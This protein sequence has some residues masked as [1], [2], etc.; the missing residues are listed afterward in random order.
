M[1]Q[2]S[3][4]SME[5]IIHCILFVDMTTHDICLLFLLMAIVL[6]CIWDCY[7]YFISIVICRD[8][9]FCCAN[10]W[11]ILPPGSSL[12][13]SW[14]CYNVFCPSCTPLTSHIRGNILKHDFPHLIHHSLTAFPCPYVDSLHHIFSPLS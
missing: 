13:H 6:I 1:Y 9:L 14:D 10:E 4:F 11:L 7:A 12:L 5:I 3:S 8:L 2:M